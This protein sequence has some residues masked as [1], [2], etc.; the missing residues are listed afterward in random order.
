MSTLK[1]ESGVSGVEL[2][3]NVGC[4]PILSLNVGCRIRK[5]GQ[6]RVS[7][8]TPLWDLSTRY[9]P[10]AWGVPLRPQPSTGTRLFVIVASYS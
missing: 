2:I 5:K 3:L 10:C 8:K 7:G 1:N 4:Q 9:L 6:C